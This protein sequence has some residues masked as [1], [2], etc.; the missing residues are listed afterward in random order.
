MDIFK[1]FLLFCLFLHE[2]VRTVAIIVLLS[3]FTKGLIINWASSADVAIY[4]IGG[5]YIIVFTSVIWLV[6]AKKTY[7]TYLTLVTLL[8]AFV[9]HIFCLLFPTFHELSVYVL[10]YGDAAIE[11]VLTWLVFTV[12]TES[13]MTSRILAGLYVYLII[14]QINSGGM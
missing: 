13:I 10:M 6:K 11:H 14:V 2:D 1:L 9:I 3:I 5:L 12:A 4:G 8:L 7:E